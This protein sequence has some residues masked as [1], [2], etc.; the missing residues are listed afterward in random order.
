[1]LCNH[2]NYS[3]LFDK[4]IVSFHL[5]KKKKHNNNR[6]LDIYIPVHQKVPSGCP[7]QSH[8]IG[9]VLI[10]ALSR[11]SFHNYFKPVCTPLVFGMAED[12]GGQ[13]LLGPEEMDSVADL[14]VSAW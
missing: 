13:V 1:M 9:D 14:R 10:T 6:N 3:S 8:M 5:H 7:K 12:A 11:I 4:F 2:K